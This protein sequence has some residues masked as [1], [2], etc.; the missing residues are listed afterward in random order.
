MQQRENCAVGGPGQW[1]PAGCKL[2]DVGEGVVGWAGAAAA[3]L[4]SGPLQLPSPVASGSAVTFP[5]ACRGRNEH[6]QRTERGSR[7]GSLGCSHLRGKRW[8]TSMPSARSARSGA[9][10]AKRCSSPLT[11]RAPT[12]KRLLC[13][14]IAHVLAA[15]G[16]APG[17]IRLHFER[18]VK[19]QAWFFNVVLQCGLAPRHRERRVEEGPGGGGGVRPVNDRGDRVAEPPRQAAA[20][21]EASQQSRVTATGAP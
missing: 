5:R 11:S 8:H 12:R 3:E 10:R 17:A 7:V 18:P 15:A 19:V 4:C 16:D 14:G 2:P 9:A 21:I 20:R 6:D 1:D 13:I